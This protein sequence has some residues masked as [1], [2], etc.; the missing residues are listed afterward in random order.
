MLSLTLKC[1]TF[2]RNDL[3]EKAWR[4]M[5][6]NVNSI[7]IHIQIERFAEKVCLIH[8]SFSF[9]SDPHFKHDKIYILRETFLL[10]NIIF[11]NYLKYSKSFRSDAFSPEPWTFST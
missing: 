10:Y 5:V 7:L 4:K 1:W 6:N 2:P 3:G 9:L 11:H 8:F